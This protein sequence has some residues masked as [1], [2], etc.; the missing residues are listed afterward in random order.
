MK[1][2]EDQLKK[3]REGGGKDE[4]EK[5]IEKAVQ[6]M[7]KPSFTQA[8]TNGSTTQAAIKDHQIMN[9]TKAQTKLQWKQIILDGDDRTKEKESK[10]IPKELIIKANLALKIGR[11]Q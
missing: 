5:I 1:E 3:Q 6:S 2:T 11:Q 4:V 7:M 10:L 8:I 9:N